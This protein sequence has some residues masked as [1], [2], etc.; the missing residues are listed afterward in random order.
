[1]PEYPGTY[2]KEFCI[3]DAKNSLSNAREE[4]NSL[5]EDS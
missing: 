3:G 4:K 2:V 1:M 5:K